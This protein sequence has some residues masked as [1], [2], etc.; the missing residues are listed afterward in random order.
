LHFFSLQ[1]LLNS[2]LKLIKVMKLLI[3]MLTAKTRIRLDS[4]S[5][6]SKDS[7]L[8]ETLFKTVLI[9]VLLTHHAI[10]SKPMQLMMLMELVMDFADFSMME[11]LDA[12]QL[13]PL[14]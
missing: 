3:T 13:L 1:Q 14:V 7:F 2:K 10:Y 11:L 6:M 9:I 5:D 12:T 4:L 8:L